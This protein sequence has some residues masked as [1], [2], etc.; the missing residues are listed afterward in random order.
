MGEL[1]ELRE[2]LEAGEREQEELCPYV[3]SKP[4]EISQLKEEQVVILQQEKEQQSL[5]PGSEEGQVA[6]LRKVFSDR[7]ALY[8]GRFDQLLGAWKSGR[9]A[10]ELMRRRLEELADFLQQLLDSQ[11]GDVTLN[12]SQLSMEL[13]DG[14]QRSIDGSRM[15]SCSVLE[16]QASLQEEMDMGGLGDDEDVEQEEWTVPELDLEGGGQEELEPWRGCRLPHRPDLGTPRVSCQ[17]WRSC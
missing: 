6:R 4:A 1:G 9:A 7:L 10:C 12:T 11:D 13:R 15:L 8:R 3:N 17:P 5:A 2:A 14:L 16:E